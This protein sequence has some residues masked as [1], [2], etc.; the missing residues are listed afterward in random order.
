M[1]SYNWVPVIPM[2]GAQRQLTLRC[3]AVT[4]PYAAVLVGGVWYLYNF[5][6]PS[7]YVPRGSLAQVQWLAVQGHKAG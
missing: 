5:Y 1:S 3:G 6:K 2:G 7:G 4:T